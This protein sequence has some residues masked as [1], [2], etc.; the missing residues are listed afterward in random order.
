MHYIIQITQFKILI[1]GIYSQK[2]AF[3]KKKQSYNQSVKPISSP[4]LFFISPKLMVTPPPSPPPKLIFDS[5]PHFQVRFF[6]CRM[7]N[8]RFSTESFLSVSL[9]RATKGQGHGQGLLI[10]RPGLLKTILLGNCIKRK[11]KKKLE[12]F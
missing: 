4:Q 8:L 2:L 10:S 3:Q 12:T 1:K 6:T 9:G 11:L 7:K 5:N